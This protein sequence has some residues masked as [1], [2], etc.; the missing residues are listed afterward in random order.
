MRSGPTA[1]TLISGYS[2]QNEIVINA[3]P[4]E[5]R[6]AILERST[7]TELYIERDTERSVVGNVIKGRVSRVLPGMQ[8]A[9]VD[10]G[11]HND[12]LVH[13]SQLADRFV[14]TPAEVARVGQAVR[15]TVL[16][17]D[18]A[19]GRIALSMKRQPGKAGGGSPPA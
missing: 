19:R 13:I 8:A 14:K 16:G 18:E 7:F 2:M 3:E 15:V 17:V 11:L 4:G 1:I 5:T 12:G 9:F 6:V 10:I